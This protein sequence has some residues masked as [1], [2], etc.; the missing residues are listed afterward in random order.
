MSKNITPTIHQGKKL[1]FI[2][3]LFFNKESYPP[4]LIPIHFALPKARIDKKTKGKKKIPTANP[5]PFQ[6]PLA[7]FKHI[8]HILLQR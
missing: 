2:A 6:N 3:F 4:T 5:L 8:L 1:L 7:K